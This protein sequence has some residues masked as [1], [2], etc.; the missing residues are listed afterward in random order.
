M[1][2]SDIKQRFTKLSLKCS[3]EIYLLLSILCIIIDNIY[4]LFGHGVTSAS[5]TCMFLYPLLGGTLIFV[6]IALTVPTAVKAFGFRLSFNLYNSGIAALTTA[7]FLNG[8]LEIAGADS[9]K[10]I[11]FYLTGWSMTALGVLTFLAMPLR[12]RARRTHENT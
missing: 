10:T 9:P 6:L 12:L 5:M 1:S 3:I 8:I 4:A 7:S 2:I 11:L